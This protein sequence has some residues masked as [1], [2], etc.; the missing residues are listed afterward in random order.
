MKTDTLSNKQF[1]IGGSS[2]FVT[3]VLLFTWA[4][5]IHRIN[6]GEGQEAVLLM[7]PY[8][9]GK[10]GIDSTPIPTGS[11]W[12][13]ITTE[14]I[15]YPVVPQEFPEHFQDMNTSDNFPVD[16]ETNI[17]LQIISG[18]GPQLFGTYGQ[19]WYINNIKQKF[20]EIVRDE[21]GNYKM[22]PLVVRGPDLDKAQKNIVKALQDYIVSTGFQIRLIRITFSKIDPDPKVMNERTETAAQQ[23]RIQSESQRK[24]AE[25]GR[26]LAEE[27][28]ALADKAYAD[29]MNLSPE[30]FVRLES[31]KAGERMVKM[32]VESGKTNCNILVGSGAN[33]QPMM[34]LR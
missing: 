25:D 13:A 29:K 17:Q 33:A 3:V 27:S 24:L 32:C 11:Q 9:F 12:V 19:A 7:K 31:I 23:Q 20:R 1:W 28:R 26:K 6:V 34:S 16:F 14:A 8:I 18:K 2:I 22:T 5:G 4:F 10:G 21:I 15:S 30:Q